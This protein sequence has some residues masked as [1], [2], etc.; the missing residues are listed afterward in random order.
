MHIQNYSTNV[1][2]TNMH[3]EK[4]NTGNTGNTVTVQLPSNEIMNS[5]VNLTSNFVD[6]NVDVDAP[7]SKSRD[8]VRDPPTPM[9]SGTLWFDNIYPMRVGKFDFRYLF[10]THNHQ[11]LIPQ[12][13]PDHIHIISMT[14]RPT[15]GGVFVDF[16]ADTTYYTTRQS[17]AQAIIKKLTDKPI[18]ALL[19][20]QPIHCHLVEGDPLLE[21]FSARFPSNRLRIELNGPAVAYNS[22]TDP[23]NITNETVDV[24]CEQLRQFG[25]MYDAKLLPFT[26]DTPRILQVQYLR[27]FSAVGARNCLHKAIVPIV[28][29]PNNNIQTVQLFIAYEPFLQTSI[30][31]D[32]FAKHPRLALPILALLFAGLTFFIFDPLRSFNITNHITKRFSWDSIAK[33]FH[34]TWF[35]AQAKL[36]SDRTTEFLHLNNSVSVNNTISWSARAADEAKVKQWMDSTP[37]SILFLAGPKGCGKQAVIQQLIH[38]RQNVLLLNMQTLLAR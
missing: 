30:I 35:Q 15:E 32:W 23:Y 33:F 2:D 29:P 20:P 4:I 22:P 19:T 38:Q 28:L 27:M 8:Q 7:R 5:N 18:R 31:T 17:V 11:L 9:L 14:P 37:D 1:N 13:L 3:I 34:L 24:I 12:I 26:K 10:S 36:I 6:V 21:D 16:K 25:R